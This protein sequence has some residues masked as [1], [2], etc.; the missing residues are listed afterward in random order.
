MGD[1]HVCRAEFLRPAALR[2]LKGIKLQEQDRK[3]LLV[4]VERSKLLGYVDT[5][6]LTAPLSEDRMIYTVQHQGWHD[7]VDNYG[8]TCLMHATEANKIDHVA[9]LL[10]AGSSKTVRS[11]D[12]YG[13]FPPGS[14]AADIA[15]QMQTKLGVDREDVLRQLEFEPPSLKHDDHAALEALG[16]L[17]FGGGKKLSF[18]ERLLA[19]KKKAEM[20]A[21]STEIM[22]R[23]LPLRARSFTQG[24]TLLLC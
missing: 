23:P 2:L 9:A 4:T 22:V 18:A 8:W 3:N 14:T 19:K 20:N 15:R 12:E 11:T 5:H 17:S 10:R 13:I 21:A 16:K 1:S 24:H 6:K 7:A